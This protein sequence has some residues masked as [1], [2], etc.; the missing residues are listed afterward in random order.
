MPGIGEAG[1]QDAFVAGD[2]RGAAVLGR[3]IGDEGEVGRGGVVGR[4]ERE[5][6]LIDPHGDLH[7]LGG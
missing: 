4:A 6:A 1:A 2:D 3:D 7:D 5:V